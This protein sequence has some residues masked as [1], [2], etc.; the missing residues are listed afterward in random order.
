MRQVEFR[1]CHPRKLRPSITSDIS[2]LLSKK[3][4]LP[5][6][7]HLLP[8]LITHETSTLNTF[9]KNTQ[10][11]WSISHAQI[12][13]FRNPKKSCLQH[14]EWPSTPSQPPAPALFAPPSPR[15]QA[16][17]FNPL[18]APNTTRSPRERPS[19]PA[20]ALTPCLCSKQRHPDPPSPPPPRSATATSPRPNPARSAT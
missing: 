13:L 5:Y 11:I 10:V 2:S 3:V 4:V 9:L 20:S 15:E 7:C 19:P 17:S 8:S 6:H 16:N 1:Q 18:Y 12:S 14:L